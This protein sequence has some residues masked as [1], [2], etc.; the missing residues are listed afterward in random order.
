MKQVSY[1]SVLLV[2]FFVSNVV[3]QQ[4]Q[5]NGLPNGFLVKFK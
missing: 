2:L 5:D 4:A 3:A 1:L